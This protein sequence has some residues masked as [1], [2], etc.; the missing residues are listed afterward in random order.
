MT[1]AIKYSLTPVARAMADEKLKL[2]KEV[3]MP[4]KNALELAIERADGDVLYALE[5]ALAALPEGTVR[6]S[7]ERFEEL[8][9]AE[10]ELNALHNGGVD[11]WEW[12]HE[13]LKNAGLL[14]DD[15]EDEDDE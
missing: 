12:Y 5:T 8:C 7:K 2:L 4:E 1:E 3:L 15:E 10:S 13:S 6:I 9:D 14:D 11:N